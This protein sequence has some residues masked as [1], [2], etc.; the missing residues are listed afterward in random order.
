MP[1]CLERGR[2]G[3]C[4][5]YKPVLCNLRTP[6]QAHVIH[7]KM[8]DDILRTINQPVVEN[9]ISLKSK[10]MVSITSN[11]IQRTSLKKAWGQWLG[12]ATGILPYIF[13]FL[14]P[15]QR[16]YQLDMKRSLFTF[17]IW[18]IFIIII[19]LQMRFLFGERI[20]DL[21]LR[22]GTWRKDL[23]VGIGLAAVMLASNFL[24]SIPI[25]KLFPYSGVGDL[26]NEVKNN[27]WL[28]ALWIGPG[29][30]IIGG[31]GEELVRVFTLTRLW[32]LSSNTAWRWIAVF[33][34]A[35]V[36]GLAHSNQGPAGVITT[37]IIGFIMAVY[38]LRFGR[39][40]VMMIAHYLNDAFTIALVYIMANT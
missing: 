26:F 8:R 4:C 27:P 12:I 15:V 35:A 23:L 40:T 36:F 39:L 10:N 7:T 25:S 20:R 2:R 13:A 28:F 31:I 14:F 34:S 33:L 5:I 6:L 1:V 19:L 38:Y 32:K 17:G 30:I 37:G 21:N 22:A 9:F 24:L 3:G 18:S 29:L 11:N 16:D